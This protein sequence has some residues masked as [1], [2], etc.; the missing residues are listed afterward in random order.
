MSRKHG[1]AMLVHGAAFLCV[2]PFR[3]IP[4]LGK[5]RWSLMISNHDNDSE[6]L[7]SDIYDIT[8]RRSRHLLRACVIALTFLDLIL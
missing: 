4:R 7:N 5:N 8:P 3:T 2:V 6:D 1:T